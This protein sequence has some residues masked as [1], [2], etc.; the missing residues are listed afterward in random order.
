ME[1]IINDSHKGFVGCPLNL[2]RKLPNLPALV[3]LK[4]PIYIK[5]VQNLF[6]ELSFPY[7]LIRDDFEII[8]KLMSDRFS[9]FLIITPQV[10]SCILELK[11]RIKRRVN[12]N[13]FCM[14]YTSNLYQ[15]FSDFA[16][17]FFLHQPTDLTLEC[18]VR[19]ALEIS[20]LRSLEDSYRQTLA[21]HSQKD[22]FSGRFLI[23]KKAIYNLA[24]SLSQGSGLGT[25]VTLIDMIKQSSP[26]VHG[27]YQV[28]PELMELLITNN[29]FSRG[30][31]EGLNTMVSILDEP[32]PLSPYSISKYLDEIPNILVGIEK[33]LSTKSMGLLYD[34]KEHSGEI[35]INYE[36]L[37]LVVE[38]LVINAYKYSIPGTQIRIYT[39]VLDNYFY[40]SVKNQVHPDFY[41]GVPEE[42]EK[43]VL[44]PFIRLYPPGDT[45]LKLDKFGLGLGLT[46]VDYIMNQ[47]SGFFSIKDEIIKAKEDVSNFVIAEISLPIIE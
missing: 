42:M 1:L 5:M 23:Q 13:C 12:F 35:H 39:R 31:I 28:D 45:N 21:I 7:V 37:N 41:G 14:V 15:D 10:D 18:S 26:L 43:L 40:L 29:D 44:E 27:V 16:F 3:Y 2:N 34:I 33:Y 9:L 47:H 4:D 46:A 17:D 8:S 20:Y 24:T 36:R 32:I 25:S 30:I 38:E 6:Q 22:H 11:D 19:S